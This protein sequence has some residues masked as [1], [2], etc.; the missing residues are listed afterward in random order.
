MAETHALT[1]PERRSQAQ[2]TATKDWPEKACL[3]CGK[4]FRPKKPWQDFCQP[5]CKL[6]SWCANRFLKAFKAGKADG[7]RDIIKELS[8]AVKL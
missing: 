6:I 8:E 7:L 1:H 2:K 5:K 4:K 3:C